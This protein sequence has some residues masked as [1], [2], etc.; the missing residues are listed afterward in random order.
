MFIKDE[1]FEYLGSKVEIKILYYDL[2][3]VSVSVL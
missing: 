1:K 2:V 3:L